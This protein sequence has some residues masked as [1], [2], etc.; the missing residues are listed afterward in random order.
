[1][2]GLCKYEQISY[3]IFR[4]GYCDVH[5]DLVIVESFV[6]KPYFFVTFELFG[7]L[8][9]FGFVMKPKFLLLLLQ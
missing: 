6:K 5:V 7:S 4:I 3:E 9:L 2:L 8:L 1:M